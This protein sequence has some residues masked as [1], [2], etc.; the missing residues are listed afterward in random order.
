MAPGQRQCGGGRQGSAVAATAAAVGV[1][2]AT[3]AVAWQHHVPELL[4]NVVE[5]ALLVHLAA[6]RT[7]RHRERGSAQLEGSRSTAARVIWRNGRRRVLI[8]SLKSG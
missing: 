2:V 1:V 3:V 5:G 4:R 8:A 6:A 7:V